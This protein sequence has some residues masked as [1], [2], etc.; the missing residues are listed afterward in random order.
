MIPEGVNNQI[1]DN[2]ADWKNISLSDMQKSLS[3]Q[4][5][6]E[7]KISEMYDKF[8]GGGY[9]E[10]QYKKHIVAFAMLMLNNQQGD[11]VSDTT[12]SNQCAD[13]GIKSI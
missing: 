5:L 2:K 13:A 12:K 10:K 8:F 6:L 9:W 7:Q 3:D 1:E 11:A 4:Y